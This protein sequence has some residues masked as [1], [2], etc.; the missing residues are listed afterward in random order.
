MPAIAAVKKVRFSV[1]LPAP[2]YDLLLEAARRDHRSLQSA[3]TVAAE[4][5]ARQVL[6]PYTEPDGRPEAAPW[7]EAPQA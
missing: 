6:G 2:T 1:G 4:W 7:G 3:L 5:Y